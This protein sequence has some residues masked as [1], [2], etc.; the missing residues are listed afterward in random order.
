MSDDVARRVFDVVD[1][2]DPDAFAKLFA[3]D[4]TLRFGNAAPNKGREAIATGLKG[5]FS[6]LAG[7]RHRIVRSWQVDA[8]VVA[9]TEVTYT[10]LD[11][12]EVGVVAV[13]IWTTGDD[14]LITDYRIFVDLAPL[15]STQGSV[16]TT[17]I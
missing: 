10:R 2:F 1:A 15:Y 4:G 5:F 6:T 16:V 9:E 17:E 7:L 13:S 11:G 12:T 8:E 3:E 14:G